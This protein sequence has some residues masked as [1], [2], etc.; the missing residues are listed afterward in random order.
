MI[1]PDDFV[2][3]AEEFGLAHNLNMDVVA[4]GVETEDVGRQPYELGC[5]YA[6]GFIFGAPMTAMDA[7]AFV[8]NYWID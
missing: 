1:G 6:Q 4:E 8:A 7:Q 2:A 5:S 3:K